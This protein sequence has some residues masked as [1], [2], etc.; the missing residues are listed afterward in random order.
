MSS[1]MSANRKATCA[2]LLSVLITRRVRLRAG[3]GAGWETQQQL[4]PDE[5]IR[6]ECKSQC[7]SPAGLVTVGGWD[8][9]QGLHRRES[10]LR[11]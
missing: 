5:I 10:E 2:D 11:H 1:R 3:A 4:G 6:Q 8:G 7:W 9:E